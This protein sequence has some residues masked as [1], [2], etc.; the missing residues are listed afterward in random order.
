[1]VTPLPLI[2]AIGTPRKCGTTYGSVAAGVIAANTANYM[3]RFAA[4]GI[5]AERVR[6]Y[7]ALFR[8]ASHRHAPRVAEMLDGVAEGARVNVDEIYALNG[9]TELIYSAN[10]D[11]GPSEC[12]AIAVLG[13]RSATGHTLL[14]QNW[15]WHPDQR[16]Y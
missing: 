1:M 4:V 13:E 10:P 8:A 7:G 2:S 5:D 16:P 14:A 6:D 3:N 9:R 11:A 12:T 15:D